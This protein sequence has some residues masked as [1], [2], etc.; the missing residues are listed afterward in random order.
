MSNTNG[1]VNRTLSILDLR[2]H[3][4]SEGS[5][6]NDVNAR[7][8]QGYRRL[9]MVDLDIYRQRIMLKESIKNIGLRN[10][11]HASQ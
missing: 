9:E 11:P 2:S 10:E 7:E 5:F 3:G 1:D 6:S 8:L 4:G